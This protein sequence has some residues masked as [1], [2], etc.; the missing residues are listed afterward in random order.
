MKTRTWIALAAFVGLLSAGCVKRTII[1]FDD[2]PT[3]QITLVEVMKQNLVFKTAEHIFYTCADQ[4]S[5][6]V[7]KRLCGGNT[8]LE[9]PKSQ[10]GSNGTVYTNVR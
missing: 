9:C 7:C 5:Q 6:L 3:Q 2:H 10:A 4:G 8:D 1:A